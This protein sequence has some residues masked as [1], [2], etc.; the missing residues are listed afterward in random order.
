MPDTRYDE[1][2]VQRCARLMINADLTDEREDLLALAHGLTGVRPEL[3]PAI[4]P[5]VD[6]LD[7]AVARAGTTLP[8]DA[9]ETF[10]RALRAIWLRAVA[11]ETSTILRSPTEPETERI[12]QRHDSYGYERDFH[13]IELERRLAENERAANGQSAHV[14][15]FSSAQAALTTL[16]LTLQA[17]RLRDIAL[18]GSYF[19]TRDLI[20]NHA[21]LRS[22]LVDESCAAEIMIVEPVACDGQFM[23]YDMPLF[24]SRLA[25][26]QGAPTIIADTTLTGHLD[27]LGPLR[28]AQGQGQ[29]IKLVSGL[30]LMQAGLELANVG[31]VTLYRDWGAHH[32][33]ALRKTR[34]LIGAGLRFSDAL[35]LEAPFFVDGQYA[36]RYGEAIFAN[37]AELARVASEHNRRFEQIDHPSFYGAA[38]P[39]CV[40]RLR[41]GENGIDALGETIAAEAKRRELAFDRGGSF[42]FRGHRFD[43]VKPENGDPAF[44]RVAMG[45]RGG[46]NKDA[47]IALM[48]DIMADNI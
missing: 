44:L 37:N 40:F 20:A 6:R 21:S 10:A 14:V 42:G 16:L 46:T 25:K 31:V 18:L 19:E 45:R 11:V 32:A 33:E 17:E 15:L 12:A 48:A 3:A 47:V 23:V 7:R 35:A 27:R 5:E 30:K 2:G 43:V 36:A 9:L 24:A 41:D 38:V 28:E 22:A 34:T 39:Y 26:A 1:D 13:P 4:A 8:D 29:L